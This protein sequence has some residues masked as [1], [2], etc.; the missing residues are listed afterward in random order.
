MFSDNNATTLS[1]S[2]FF[3]YQVHVILLKTTTAKREWLINKGYKIIS[4]IPV[5]IVEY[6]T[7]QEDENCDTT[8]IVYS[9]VSSMP[10]SLDDDLRLTSTSDVREQ[11]MIVLHNEIKSDL[12]PLRNIP[13]T[14][15]LAQVV[16][17][18]VETVFQPWYRNVRIFPRAKRFSLLSMVFIFLAMLSMFKYV[19]RLSKFPGM[20]NKFACTRKR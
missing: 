17:L 16:R 12:N 10:L 13:S 8:P 3:A 15:L 5:H 9:D 11:N 14:V 4:F 19:R 20:C 18:E 2:A 6:H 1:R 7:E